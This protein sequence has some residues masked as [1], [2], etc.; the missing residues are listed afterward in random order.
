MTNVS[1]GPGWG[2]GVINPLAPNAELGLVGMMTKGL[3]VPIAAD[4][5][6]DCEAVAF[7]RSRCLVKKSE[8][9]SLRFSF[10]DAR[11]SARSM[12]LSPCMT[13]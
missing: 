3:G 7:N 6:A 8:V 13:R 4:G 12:L 5:A 2:T 1:A 10:W 11:C 9:A